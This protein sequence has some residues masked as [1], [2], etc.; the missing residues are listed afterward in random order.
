MRV[1]DEDLDAMLV[2]ARAA[3]IGAAVHAIGDRAAA[4]VLDAFARAPARA[5]GVPPDRMEHLQLVRAEDRR[6][7]AAAG[8]TASIQPI[9]AAADRDLVEECWDGR[10]ADAYAW[11]SL[12]DAGARLAAGSDA[13]VESVNP[14][15]GV[16]ASLHRRLPSDDR[17]D[18]RPA[19]ALEMAEALEAY[20]IGPARAI[21][22]ADEGHLRIGAK[23][24]LAV[25]SVGLDALLAGSVD[26]GAV[27]S[28]LT[29]VD[30]RA[31]S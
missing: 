29:L 18:W 6:R 15:L 12:R 16:F 14:W 25:L 13:P 7:V 2:R 10:Q 24:D 9:H 31:P 26:F 19:E 4:V 8:I 3:R 28:T 11:R 17:G 30:G 21:G 20:T 23:A 5:A 22:A 27:R 1:S